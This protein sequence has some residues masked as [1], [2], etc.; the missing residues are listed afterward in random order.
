M[1]PGWD[2]DAAYV[3]RLVVRGLCV[4][5]SAIVLVAIACAWM[6]LL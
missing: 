1:S 2:S 3:G 5:A 6:V 4:C